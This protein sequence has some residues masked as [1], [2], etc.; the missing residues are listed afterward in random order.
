MSSWPIPG[1]HSHLN[2][3]SLGMSLCPSFHLKW[4][5]H[6]R[7]LWGL[8]GFPGGSMV[9]NLPSNAGDGG[10]IPV[11]GRCP[12]EGNTTHSSILAWEIPWTEE[13]G[14]LQST[15]SQRVGL[16][17]VIEQRWR[18]TA[19]GRH[20]VLIAPRPRRCPCR[21]LSLLTPL[22]QVPV[23]EVPVLRGECFLCVGR[24]T[25]WSNLC[26][27]ASFLPVSTVSLHIPAP[28]VPSLLRCPA[29]RGFLCPY[30]PRRVG[31]RTPLRA[32]GTSSAGP[33]LTHRGRSSVS[34]GS[35]ENRGVL[36]T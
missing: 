26:P 22:L 35:G 17:L 12:G 15:G 20:L 25:A 27:P 34:F 10:L 4:Q 7:G 33:R 21:E 8:T 1:K 14:G 28:W 23:P 16:G 11:S 30:C 31:C 2:S 19:L 6:S 5:L 3:H 32:P 36:R 9:K 24:L 18:L 29:S 13:L